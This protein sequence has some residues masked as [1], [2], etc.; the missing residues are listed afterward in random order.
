MLLDS[1]FLIN[2]AI[3]VI[4]AKD[5]DKKRKKLRGISNWERGMGNGEQL[6]ILRRNRKKKIPA[7][8]EGLSVFAVDIDLTAGI[9]FL[10]KC[11]NSLLLTPITLNQK[12]N[13]SVVKIQN[14]ISSF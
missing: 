4:I 3:P 14:S 6:W 8:V 13:A 2:S 5:F 12:Q 11:L 9:L 1:Q 7:V 10:G